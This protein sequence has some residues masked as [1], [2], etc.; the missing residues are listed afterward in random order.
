MHI[1][2]YFRLLITLQIKSEWEFHAL[3]DSS[4]N[5]STKDDP[6]FNYGRFETTL[7]ADDVCEVV[8]Q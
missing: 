5:Y 3:R 1:D 7:R 8:F 4:G 6:M 2:F